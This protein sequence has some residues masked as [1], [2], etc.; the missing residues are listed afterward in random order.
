[1]KSLT[2]RDG[3]LL[4][5]WYIAALSR[6]VGKKPIQRTLYD[7]ALV[8][9]RNNDGKVSCLNDRCL[10]RHAFLS[11][12]E[13]FK[14]ELVCP[15]HGWLYDHTG[16][17]SCVPSEGPES[18]PSQNLKLKSFPCV[19]QDGVIWVWMGPSDNNTDVPCPATP[20]W[21][22][23]EALNPD[24]ISY[25]MITDFENEVTNLA[26]N[27]VDVPHTIFVHR[28]WF[29]DEKAVPKKVP[30]V[31]E[32]KNGAVT[33]TY[34]QE[35]DEFSWGAKMLLNPGGHPMTHT[36]QFIMPNLTR[37][38]YN[39][40]SKNGFIINSQISPVSTLKSRVY[41]YIAYKIPLFGM[42][43]KP[44]ISFYTRKV[45]EQDT[46]I[47]KNQGD[48]L[49]SDFRTTFRST[50]ADEV[51]KEIERLRHYGVKGDSK[52]MSY[53]GKKEISFWI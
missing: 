11:K 44:I 3:L 9:F 40:G 19:E 21:R 12:G 52:L 36:D 45:I 39:F 26:E 41:T 24:W 7:T 13:V 32:T 37:V 46:V 23:P 47:M 2:E 4:K 43:F 30:T 38:D 33:V 15:Y 16:Q 35:E 27:F 51:H 34:F 5:N 1:M 49:R 22:F 14:G 10:H 18:K 31:V 8:L 20:P 28:G 17:V 48:C 29:R 42:L 25:F 50:E 6:E 53:E